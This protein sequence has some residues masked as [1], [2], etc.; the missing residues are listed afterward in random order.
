MQHA[1]QASLQRITSLAKSDLFK[2][3]SRGAQGKVGAVQEGLACMLQ[4]RKPSFAEEQA[5]DF[6][7]DI[8]LR[9]PYFLKHNDGKKDLYG[10]E[11]MQVMVK[12]LEA[13]YNEGVATMEVLEPFQVFNFLLDAASKDKVALITRKVMETMAA[14]VKMHKKAVKE[15]K[16]SEEAKGYSAVSAALDMFR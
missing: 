14:Q 8:M 13:Q 6:M 3:A 16:V 9:F 2:F 7:N 5:G 11:A 1:I 15:T 4:G 10:K 12:K